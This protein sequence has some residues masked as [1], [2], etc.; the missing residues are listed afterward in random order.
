MDN[1]LDVGKTLAGST[2][3][4]NQVQGIDHITIAVPDL[5]AAVDWYT[6]TLGLHITER[7]HTVG[8]KS[9]MISAVLVLG[10]VTIVL[11]QGTNPQSQISRFIES[12]GPGV[13]H[14]AFRVEE[15][16]KVV[17]ELEGRGLEFS[18]ELL[19]SPGLKQIFSR[20]HQDSG[21][22]F[23][24]IERHDND[25]FATENVQ[26]LFEQLEESDSF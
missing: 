12:Y 18:T 3:F 6:K 20:R 14:V 21:M 23:E 13:Q 16:A 24:L 2:L 22:M 5:E 17:D 11:V 26:S 7:R 25:G 19:V 8:T 10:Q 4:A 9:G 1:A 15:I